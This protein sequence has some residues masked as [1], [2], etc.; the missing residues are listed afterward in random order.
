MFTLDSNIDQFERSFMRFHREQVPFATSLAINET[1]TDIHADE[2]RRLPLVLDRPTN[3]TRRGLMVRRSSKRKLAGEVRY[4][5]IQRQYLMKQETGGVRRP[6]GKA[7]V[8]PVNQRLNKFGNLSRGAIKRL[9]ARPDVFS[10]QVNGVGGIWQRPRKKGGRLKL[11]IAYEPKATYR[12]RLRFEANAMSVARRRMRENM[13][14]AMRRA[15]R[16]AR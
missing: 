8:V 5:D 14:M 10:G 3:F 11:L 7:L 15:I 12:P 4:K 13:A 9:M 6:S 16:S 2:E 1:L